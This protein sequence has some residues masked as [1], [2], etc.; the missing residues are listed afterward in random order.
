MLTAGVSAATSV[1]GSILIYPECLSAVRGEITPEM[2]PFPNQ[3]EI[4]SA[5]CALQDEGE[6]VDPVTIGVRVKETGGEWSNSYALQLIEATPT[7]ANVLEWCRLLRREAMARTLEERTRQ[8]SEDLQTGLDPFTVAQELTAAIED[9]SDMENA[10]GVVSGSEAMVEL[11]E[12][13]QAAE[14]DP[15]CLST[16]FRALDR[17]LGGGLMK[18]CLYILAA[19][20]GQGKTTLG[21]AVAETVAKAG[22]TVLFVSLEMTR[23]QLAARRVAAYVGTVTATQVLTGQCVGE[24]LDK[25]TDA[26][27]ALSRRKILFNR[28]GR[29]NVREIQFLA[30]KNQA[31]L[32]V[33]D[34]LGLIRHEDGKSLYEKVTETS[35]RLKQMTVLLNIPVLCL[36]QLNREVEGRGNQPPRLSDLRDS[37]AIEQ[38]A[39][40]VLLLHRLPATEEAPIMAHLNLIIA[41]NRYGPQGTVTLDW[42]LRNGRVLGG[43]GK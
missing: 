29:V 28:R 30:R 32:V 26:M 43:P 40:A 34:Y 33:I 3:R 16:G 20:P 15:P 35:N 4:Y 24:D 12:A 25:V 17:I 22:R 42:S 27:T 1:L 23:Q 31:D 37:G 9:I 21:T 41:K 38:D 7:A 19:R 6:P 5:A 2:F 14:E 18:G 36:A 13:I 39:D 8:A 10:A 11:G